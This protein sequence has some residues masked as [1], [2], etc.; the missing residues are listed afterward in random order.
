MVGLQPPLAAITRRRWVVSI[1]ALQTDGHVDMW[2]CGQMEVG[3]PE[4][5]CNTV[6]P[7]LSDHLGAQGYYRLGQVV[8]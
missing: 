8:A 5:S 2:T 4:R 6:K 3:V 1:G 7:V